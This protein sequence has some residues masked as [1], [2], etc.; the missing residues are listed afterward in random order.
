VIV[1]KL[2]EYLQQAPH[3]SKVRED[4]VLKIHSLGEKYAPSKT[5]Y[6][7]TMNTLFEMGGNLI[8]HDICNKF[9]KVVS[10]F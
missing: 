3:E 5:W 9:I 4:L 7:K 10:D 6:V 8:T 1:D 2:L